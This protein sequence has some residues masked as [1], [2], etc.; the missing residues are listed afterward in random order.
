MHVVG[1]LTFYLM[2]AYEHIHTEGKYQVRKSNLKDPR[3]QP[4]PSPL[5]PLNTQNQTLLTRVSRKTSYRNEF[6]FAEITSTFYTVSCFFVRVNFF[7]FFLLFRVF[8]TRPNLQLTACGQLLKCFG[9]S[10]FCFVSLTSGHFCLVT[11]RIALD[12]YTRWRNQRNPATCKWNRTASRK[13]R[14][15]V[16]ERMEQE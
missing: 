3:L 16:Y 8:S 13:I 1:H 10:C 2:H 12:R 9:S 15:H 11:G 4:P 5:S 6:F 14:V 7:F